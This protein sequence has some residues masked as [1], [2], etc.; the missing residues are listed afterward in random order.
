VTASLA[1]AMGLPG[2]VVFSDAATLGAIRQ[3]AF[4]GA[5]SPIPPAYLAAFVRTGAL[6]QTAYQTLTANIRRAEAWLLPTGRFGHIPGYPVFYT[7]HD[8]L[9]PHLLER[10]ML[11]YQF[12]YPTPA[13]KPNTRIVVSALHTP[14]DLDRLGAAVQHY[15]QHYPERA[16]TSPTT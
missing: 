14:D 3:T 12:A 1:K 2:G 5:C 7:P 16:L 11:I 4:F 13:D 9:Y 6:Y 10:D 15:H 8:D